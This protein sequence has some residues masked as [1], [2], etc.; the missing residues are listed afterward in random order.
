MRSVRDLIGVALSGLTSR[1]SR[2]LLI[3]L[4]PI[5][6]V[7][8][9]VA[10][11]GLTESAKGDLQQ[12]LAELGTNL[13]TADAAGSFGTQNPTF[14]EDV[15]DRVLALRG[16]ESATATLS[17][18]GVVTAPYDAA[19]TYYTAFPTPV[20]TADAAFLDVMQ[21][22]LRSGRWLNDFDYTTG[23]RVAVIGLDVAN[24]FEYRAGTNRTIQISGLDY[25]IVGVYAPVKL[26]TNFNTAVLIPPLTAD[27]DFDVG[28]ETNTLYVRADPTRVVEVE[29]ALPVAINL[30]G[31]DE[32][33][34]SVPSDALEAAAAADSTLQVIVA[35]MGILAL[36]VGGVGI[37]NVMSISVIQRSAEIGIRR[38]LGHGRALIAWQFLLEA[39]AVGFFGGLGGLALGVV[40]VIY[41]S[42]IA[43]WTYVLEPVL[44]VGGYEFPSEFLGVPT[45]YALGMGAALFTSVVAGLYPSV[46]AARLEPLETLRLG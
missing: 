10:A 29:E 38:A 13:I 23:A 2:T 31:S 26:V 16:V 43:G 8:A 18:T 15:R 32:V 5:I 42:H 45:I 33:N 20:L 9:I 1:V 12:D 34:T 40:I 11:V 22:E 35:S 14:P 25:G 39:V 24:E 37:A 7:S 44:V 46:K 27:N 19:A 6:G 17:I 4:G 30:G 28:L 41:A 3:M 21:I 36:V